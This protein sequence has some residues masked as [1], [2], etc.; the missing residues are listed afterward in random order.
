MVDHLYHSVSPSSLLFSFIP[1]D[2]IYNVGFSLSVV[3]R[4]VVVLFGFLASFRFF[5]TLRE[6]HPNEF[7]S[8]IAHL[9][10]E[11]YDNTT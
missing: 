9:M 3:K 10:V 5:S 7:F 4:L 1:L 6:Y 2:C 11:M 8:S